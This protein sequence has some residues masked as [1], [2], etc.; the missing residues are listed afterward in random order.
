MSDTHVPSPAVPK[1]PVP[2]SY[3]AQVSRIAKGLEQARHENRQLH[4]RVAELEHER[5]TLRA[6]V[7]EMCRASTKLS[8]VE[9]A[10]LLERTLLAS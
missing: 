9:F 7:L 4:E 6:R 5:D 3:E 8:P 2:E 1:D 10:R